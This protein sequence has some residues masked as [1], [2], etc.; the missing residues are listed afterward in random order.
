MLFICSDISRQ[1]S[2]YTASGHEKEVSS[3]IKGIDGK[4]E[5]EVLDNKSLALATFNAYDYL[6]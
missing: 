2:L 4:K 1:S 3:N 6:L 5:E